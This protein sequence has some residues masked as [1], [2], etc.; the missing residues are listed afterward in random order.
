M[1]AHRLSEHDAQHDDGGDDDRNGEGHD[2]S[3]KWA[4]EIPIL[5]IHYL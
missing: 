2:D 4:G 3:L 5:F 1:V